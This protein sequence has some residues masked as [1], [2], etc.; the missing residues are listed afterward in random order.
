MAEI[1]Q[2]IVEWTQ[3]HGSMQ[4]APFAVDPTVKSTNRSGDTVEE[5]NPNPVY[6]Y[7]F[8]DG[9]ALEMN[10]DGQ[11]KS[12][13]E[14]PPSAAANDR[15]GYQRYTDSKTGITYES[16]TG[17][18]WSQAAGLPVSPPVTAT[19]AD[20]LE[21]INDPTTHKP[22]KLR[23]PKTGT[24]IDLPDATSSKPSIVQGAG[25]AIYSWD[26]TNLVLKQA[27]TAPEVKPKEGDT[28]PNVQGGYAITEKFTGGQWVVDPSVPPTPWDPSLAGKP[29]A[30][31]TRQ[32]VNDGYEIREKYTGG[33]WVTD[34]TF[35]PRPFDPSLAGKPK[36]GDTRPNVVQG[37]VVQ[38]VYRGGDWVID[39]S[40]ASRPYAPG[41][42]APVPGG[43]T[44]PNITFLDP[45]TGQLTSQP[46]PGYTS[47]TQ[48]RAQDLY[49]SIED[50][51]GRMTRGEMTPADGEKYITALRQNFEAALRGTTPYQEYLDRQTREQTRMTSGQSLL[52]QRVASGSGLAE[53][54]LNSAVGIVGNKNFMDPSAVAGL[55]IFQGARDY[56]TDLGG[57]QG[58][59]DA[60]SG[61]V[62]RG[63]QGDQQMSD[64]ASALLQHALGNG[65]QPISEGVGSGAAGPQGPQNP[66]AL[67]PTL[68]PPGPY[69]SGGLGP[70]AVG[71]NGQAPTV[72]GSTDPGL[73]LLQAALGGR[74]YRQP[75]QLQAAGPSQRGPIYG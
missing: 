49:L 61:A 34:P 75:Q 28:R 57:G 65:A 1:D 55:S 9:S 35:T 70:V 58:V 22:I 45:E 10:G 12:T 56:V 64:P 37:Q 44:R 21:I 29:K 6:R 63:L 72:T 43:G 42:P 17:H 36:D 60:A 5:P 54:L 47:A 69:S 23:D 8:A 59:Y 33:Q 66:S 31:D 24:V 13:S 73:A 39:P 2:I 19:P 16:W 68:L 7:T 27:G 51:R 67:D 50:I 38:Q 32:N 25:G 4:G 20:Q 71:N 15:P 62:T 3:K 18:P 48:Q 30:G 46:D 14:K 53:S 41:K 26:G 40:V 52:N 74:N 11:I